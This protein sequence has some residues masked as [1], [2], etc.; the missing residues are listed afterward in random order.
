MSSHDKP[1][2]EVTSPDIDL[3]APHFNKS[4]FD[5]AVYEHG[6][7]STIERAIR[8]PCRIEA[9]NNGLSGCKN[10]GG[11]GWLFVNKRSTV[12]V[13]QSMNT[14]TK[15]KTWNEEDRGTISISARPEDRLGFMDRVTILDLESTYSEIIRIRRYKGRL[16]ATTIYNP[17]SI[18][19]VYLF[20]DQK[21]KLVPLKRGDD[22]TVTNNV[23]EL[24]KKHE[25]KFGVKELISITIRYIHYPSY[26]VIDI[27]RERTADRRASTSEGNCILNKE[28]TNKKPQLVI[29]AIARKAQ[30][31]IDKP[32]LEGVGLFD[33]SDSDAAIV[34]KTRCQLANERISNFE[35]INCILP[36][37]DFK[38]DE[39]KNALTQTQRNDLISAVG[40]KDTLDYYFEN[41]TTISHKVI[42]GEE[43][44][45]KTTT[46]FGNV[47]S[48][49]Y[50][51][52]GNSIVLPV[53]LSVGDVLKVTIS[54]TSQSN[55]DTVKFNK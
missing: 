2:I 44:T 4:D 24:N 15:N 36:T 6:F 47:S 12:I 27:P 22:Y 35:K 53:T 50:E 5:N 9:N 1:I 45:Y 7:D 31:A 37:L 20:T 38:L 43:G 23:F 49:T 32:N 42:S 10:C 34:E 8:C 18:E 51:R 54:R 55:Q 13:S 17:N 3:T 19:F 40:A 16:L 28:I 26:H 21:E 39:V 52:N 48:A 33:N 11:S 46:F 25:D 29:N 14:S 30:Y 41:N